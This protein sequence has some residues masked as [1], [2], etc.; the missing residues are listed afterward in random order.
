MRIRYAAKTD[1]GMKRTH[2]E[3]YFSLIEDEQLFL[4]AD[5]MGGHASGEV[6]SKMAADAIQEFYSRTKDDDATWP[7]KMDRHLSFIEN[8]QGSGAALFGYTKLYGQ[9]PGGQAEFLRVPFGD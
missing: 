2:N 7:Y 9:V 8:E 4:V 6:A 5:G 3:D 1:V